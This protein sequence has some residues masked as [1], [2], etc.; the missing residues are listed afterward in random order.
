MR[1]SSTSHQEND[2]SEWLDRKPLLP[3]PRTGSRWFWILRIVH[4]MLEP[5][6]P[7][8][9]H[10]TFHVESDSD[11]QVDVASVGPHSAVDSGDGCPEVDE[12]IPVFYVGFGAAAQTALVGLDN[13]DLEDE[14]LTK[15]RVMKC[16]PASLRGVCKASMKFVLSE[17]DRA[18][19]A[20][21]AAPRLGNCFFSFHVCCSTVLRVAARSRSASRWNGSL[22]LPEVGG[23]LGAKSGVRNPSIRRVVTSSSPT[24]KGYERADRAQAM[25][26]VGEVLCWTMCPRR[27]PVPREPFRD[28]VFQR[29]GPSFLLDHDIFA[30]N[31][32]VARGG[33]AAGLS[34]MT[35]DNS[36]RLLERVNKIQDDFGGL[37]KTSP[38]LWS[39]MKWSTSSAWAVSQHFR[40]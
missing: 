19:D 11:S 23:S 2:G 8:Q 3:C 22:I 10:P 20:G 15:A 34:G 14:F 29:G 18:R 6:P 21:D 39:L 38:A 25:V 35:A 5:P 4:V 24:S 37:H 16:F 30:K 32:R 40:N 13:V 28:D 12:E 9:F 36:R 33:A 27:P 31:F 1:W 26:L 7:A 17:A